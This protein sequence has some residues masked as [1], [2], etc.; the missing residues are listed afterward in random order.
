MPATDS[1]S[2]TMVTSAHSGAIADWLP[3]HFYDPA[4]CGGGAMMDLGAHP[5]YMARWILGG[6]ARISSTFNAFTDHPVE[7]NAVCVIEFENKAVAIVETGFVTPLSPGTLELYGTAGT[8]L[9]G[10][11]EGGVRLRSDRVQADVPGWIAPTDLPKALPAPIRQWVDAVVHG[12]EIRYGL[13]E[14][15]QLTELMQ[16]AYIAHREGRQVALAELRK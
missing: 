14:G 3:P 9:I 15:F 8:L 10:G 12:G 16:A 13:E 2:L 6:P 11:A 5:M 4:T 1:P 7:D